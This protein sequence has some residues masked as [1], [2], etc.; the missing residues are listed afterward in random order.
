MKMNEWEI[1]YELLGIVRQVSEQV[2]MPRSD[3]DSLFKR[4]ADLDE[5]IVN[6]PVEGE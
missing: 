6:L 1:L 4:I 5:K 3:L 2:M